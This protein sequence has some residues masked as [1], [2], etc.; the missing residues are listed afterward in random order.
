[1]FWLDY[2]DKQHKEVPVAVDEAVKEAAEQIEPELHY[3]DVMNVT[4][5]EHSMTLDE[6][7]ESWGITEPEYEPVECEAEP[8]QE[9]QKVKRK[10]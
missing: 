3:N 6:Y 10:K 4:K 1:M 8:P 2:Q 5:D 7:A 9:H